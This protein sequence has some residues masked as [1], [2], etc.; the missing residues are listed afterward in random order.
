MGKTK[1]VVSVSSVLAYARCAKLFEFLNFSGRQPRKTDYYRIRGAEVSKFIRNLYRK[2]TGYRKFFYYSIKSATRDWY[3]VW[4]IAMKDNSEVLSFVDKGIAKEQSKIGAACI[5]NYWIQN[6][7]SP[8]PLKIKN[9]EY[10]VRIKCS[11]LP[12]NYLSGRLDHIV[13]CDISWIKA[14]RPE[15]IENGDLTKD[16]SPN[17]IVKYST[18]M[19]DPVFKDRNPTLILL[20][21]GLIIQAAMNIMLYKRQFGTH[22]VGYLIYWLRYES[23]NKLLI[24][25]DLKEYRDLL[26]LVFQRMAKSITD[27]KFRKN[28]TPSCAYCDYVLQCRP[29][30]VKQLSLP[31]T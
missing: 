7:D 23:N 11:G 15:I 29:E 3:R 4:D 17:L 8:E 16:Y 27:H 18:S 25:G 26:D 9:I 5:K 6:L 30:I 1:S 2:H 14:A 19:L 12:Y 20:P 31:F 10:T 13:P 28:L 21:D 24:N 22:P